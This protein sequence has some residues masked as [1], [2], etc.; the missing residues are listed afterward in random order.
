M[1]GKCWS[2]RA[3]ATATITIATLT[4]LPRSSN[5]NPAVHPALAAEDLEEAVAAA[6]V[7]VAPLAAAPV[8]DGS[9]LSGQ[10]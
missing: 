8:V 5:P 2:K 7:V 4:T 10:T 1:A 9:E 3:V 6:L